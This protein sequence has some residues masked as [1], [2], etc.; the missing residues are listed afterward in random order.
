MLAVLTKHCTC[1]RRACGFYSQQS[2]MQNLLNINP[3]KVAVK[4]T[5]FPL[6]A[7]PWLLGTCLRLQCKIE[8]TFHISRKAPAFLSR[9]LFYKPKQHPR[10]SACTE[11]RVGFWGLWRSSHVCSRHFSLP[12]LQSASVDSQA[13]PTPLMALHRPCPGTE[14][15][16]A[17]TRL[18]SA[19]HA[20]ARL[21]EAPAANCQISF[22]GCQYPTENNERTMTVVAALL[23]K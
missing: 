15:H 22:I 17:H 5:P 20:I 23:Y 18:A 4:L 6:S 14:S 7:Y 11:G 3:V 9:H 10:L 1:R 13:S 21:H 12:R 8:F 2:Q 16:S 19:A